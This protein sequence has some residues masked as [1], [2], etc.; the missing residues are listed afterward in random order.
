[1]FDNDLVLVDA[2]ANSL[3]QVIQED[4]KVS[5]WHFLSLLFSYNFCVGGIYDIWV[6]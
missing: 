5:W 4:T 1:M 2:L 6:L 3:D